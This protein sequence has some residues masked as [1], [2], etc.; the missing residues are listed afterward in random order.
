[1]GKRRKIETKIF[2]IGK[3]RRTDELHSPLNGPPNTNLDFYDKK[4]G[5]FV[6]RRKFGYDGTANKDLDKQHHSHGNKDHAHDF[7]G[8]KRGKERSLTTK[9]KREVKKA[10]KKR[11]FWRTG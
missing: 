2:Q 4:T 9:E 8:K 11:R 1:M 5:E 7:D 6:G 3:G 10:S